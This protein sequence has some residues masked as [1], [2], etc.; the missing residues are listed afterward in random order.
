M[1]ECILYLG[2]FDYIILRSWVLNGVMLI[3]DGNLLIVGSGYNEIVGFDGFS[4]SIFMLDYNFN[5]VIF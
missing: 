2:N 1:I 4:F 3:S 5:V